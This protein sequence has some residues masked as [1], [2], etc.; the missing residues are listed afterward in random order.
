MQRAYADGDDVNFGLTIVGLLPT[1]QNIAK[2]QAQTAAS[3][4]AYQTS[5]K[6]PYPYGMTGGQSIPLT[7]IAPAPAPAPKPIAVAPTP[8][9]APA[10]APIAI[11]KPTPIAIIPNVTLAPTPAPAPVSQPVTIVPP[12]TPTNPVAVP[13]TSAGTAAAPAPMP[14]SFPGDTTNA[15]LYYG[16]PTGT[17][18]PGVTGS[19]SSDSAS[20][21]PAS[22]SSSP[23]LW[24][25]G[26][27]V[28]LLLMGKK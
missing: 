26:A 25:A 20:T 22:L 23:M 5:L 16:G 12:T 3:N 14:H 13:A 8:A 4:L 10:P 24:I 15:G 21:S 7:T 9:P 28:L 2:V 17:A 27:A 1:A 19:G 6:S 11:P 18:S